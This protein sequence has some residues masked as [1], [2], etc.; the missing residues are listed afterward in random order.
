LFPGGKVF[1]WSAQSVLTVWHSQ[2]TL[3]E[4]S[5]SIAGSCEMPFDCRAFVGTRTATFRI[6][7]RSAIFNVLTNTTELIRNLDDFSK[8]A[9]TK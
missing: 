5:A 6:T 9:E 3:A 4:I 1:R 8:G 7:M 2:K